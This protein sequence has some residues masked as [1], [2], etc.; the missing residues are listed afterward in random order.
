M[1]LSPESHMPGLLTLGEKSILYSFRTEDFG[2]YMKYNNIA[3][4]D[5][6]AMVRR[7]FP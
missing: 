5:I 2:T 3:S 1:Q 7:C 4:N 6:F